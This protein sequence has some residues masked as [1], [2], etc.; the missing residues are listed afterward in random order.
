MSSAPPS[1]RPALF[2]GDSPVPARIELSESSGPVSPAHQY[3][4]DIELTAGPD[5]ITLRRKVKRDWKA[6]T[7]TTSIDDTVALDR[8]AYEQLWD[9]LLAADV[10]AAPAKKP[11]KA[12]PARMGGSDN[13]FTVKLGKKTL[14]QE[15]RTSELARSTKPAWVPVLERLR[16]LADR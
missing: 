5:G 8:A 16:R 10:F 11:A 2:D 13:H 15:F 14:T 12:A 9:D 6:G 7:F 4:V 3:F 1:G